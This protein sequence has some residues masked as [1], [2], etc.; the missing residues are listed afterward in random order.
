M[1]IPD[2]V[3]SWHESQPP[4]Y[5]R[6]LSVSIDRTDPTRQ[7]SIYSQIPY[8]LEE[9]YLTIRLSGEALLIMMNRCHSELCF[10]LVKLWKAFEQEPRAKFL[11]QIPSYNRLSAICTSNL[12]EAQQTCCH[13]SLLQAHYHCCLQTPRRPDHPDHFGL[14]KTSET[15]WKPRL[16]ASDVYLFFA[17]FLGVQQF[18][19]RHWYPELVA[20][21]RK[22]LREIEYERL[23]VSKMR[24]QNLS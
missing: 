9:S 1:T 15:M 22:L 5:W 6:P 4:G 19:S 7:D 8:I 12:V 17:S 21:L 10:W 20:P 2:E 16:M 13:P 14:S 18:R 11:R 3:L 24:W 23:F